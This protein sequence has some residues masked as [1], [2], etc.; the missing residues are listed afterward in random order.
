MF[1]GAL[2]V[3][4]LVMA[5]VTWAL[6][7]GR[8]T[9]ALARPQRLIVGGGL[10]LPPVLLAGLLVYGSVSSARITGSADRVEARI[11][12]VAERWRWRFRHLDDDGRVVA[13]TYNALGCGRW[14][15]EWA[16]ATGRVE[17][18]ERGADSVRARSQRRIGQHRQL[19]G[20]P[21]GA[22]RLFQIRNRL[23]LFR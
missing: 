7:R 2:V 14:S 22:A 4:M 15:G 16:M 23:E 3:W 19:L 12:V 18:L 6:Y 20:H 21:T 10:V 1:W 9:R 5:L 17:H 11:D 13:E 8:N